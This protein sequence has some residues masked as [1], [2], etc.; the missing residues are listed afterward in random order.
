MAAG[1]NITWKKREWGRN[2]IFSIIFRLLGR[3][4]SGD[5]NFGGENQD[6]KKGGGKEYKVAGN[7]IHPW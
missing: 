6:S 1:K 2:I 7:F 5:G 4:S 3:V